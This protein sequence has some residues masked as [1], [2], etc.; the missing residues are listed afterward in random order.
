VLQVLQ[1]L[2]A[3][4]LGKRLWTPRRQELQALQA[5]RRRYKT[6]R[7]DVVL[8]EVAPWITAA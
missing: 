5:L 4:R 3:L 1:G 8:F 2:Q 7:L 6:L